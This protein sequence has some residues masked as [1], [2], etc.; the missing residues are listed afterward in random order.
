MAILPFP[1]RRL[2]G[3]G[4]PGFRRLDSHR[5]VGPP[6]GRPRRWLGAWLLVVAVSASGLPPV[7]GQPPG[8]VF[9]VEVGEAG[10]SD[11]EPA[12][13]SVTLV[14]DR[15]R[16]RQLDRCRRLVADGRWSDAAAACDELLADDRDAFIDR[17]D[18]GTTVRSIRGE[19][20][21][22]IAALPRP[23]RD[24]YLRLFR[25]RAERQLAE[26]VATGDEAGIAAVAR[27]WFHTP[28]GR[29]A[30]VI[31][32]V[33]AME[34]G[35]PLTAID[36]LDRIAAAEEGAE[37]EPTLT[38]MRALAR[39]QAGV[40]GALEM[41]SESPVGGRSLRLAG[42]DVELSAD[43]LADLL[44]G[45]I[46]GQGPTVSGRLGDWRQIRGGAAR[47]TV[48]EASRPLLVPRYRVPLTPHPAE[49][50]KLEQ[51][52]RTAADA[53]TPLLPAGNP[54]A[55]G[56][57]LVVRTSLGILAVDFETGKRRWLES[58]VPVEEPTEEGEAGSGDR[59]SGVFDDA[60]SGNLSSDG[61]LVFAVE[62]RP[63][64]MA[65]VEPLIRVFG[66][67]LVRHPAA[68]DG[69]NTLTAYDLEAG[70]GIR[71]QLPAKANDIEAGI[72][73]DE[74]AWFLGAP[75]VSGGE[76]LLLVERGG[77]A[78]LE[79]R[80]AEDGQ[81]L[82]RQPLAAYDDNE[83]I[84]SPEAHARRLAGLTPA[85]S[86]GVLVCPLGGG[87][88]V[89]FD[90]V[91]RTLLWSH[92]YQ[93]RGTDERTPRPL[94]EPCPVIVGD[95][96]LFNPFDGDGFMCLGLRD[97]RPAWPEPP[98]GRGRVAGVVD[99]RVI[100]VGDAAVEA[101]DI[102][103]GRRL[104]RLPL[105]DFGRPSGR[106]VTTPTSLLLPLDTPEVVEIGL[107]VGK[108][109]SRSP[110]RGGLIPGN[111]VAHRGEIVSQGVDSLD[112]FH[113]EAALDSRIE[114]AR[115]DAPTAPWAAYWRGQTAVE[116]GDVGTGLELV[117]SALKQG[118]FRIPPGGM[119]E[120]LLR[121]LARDFSTAARWAP[122]AEFIA[123]VP[124]VA[125]SYVDGC[126]AAGETAAAWDAFQG[127][128]A[129][130]VD[131]P[132]EAV[133]R[134]PA[135]PFLVLAADRWVRG[136]LARI[137]DAADPPLRERIDAA[138]RAAAAAAAADPDSAVRQRRME[139]VAERLGRHPAADGLIAR[140]AADVPAR[141]GRQAEV[142]A[143]LLALQTGSPPAESHAG[144]TDPDLA[145]P[146]GQVRRGRASAAGQQRL[147]GGY[148]SPLAPVPVT[149][150]AAGPRPIQARLDV[151][152]RRLFLTDGFGR[153]VTEPLPLEGA[154]R[155]LATPWGVDALEVA[156]AG[157]V[158]VVR[159][160]SE[161]VAYDIGAAVGRG[162]GL[163]R[164]PEYA[165]GGEFAGRSVAGNGRV[166]R[167]GSVSLGMRI[168]EPDE[169]PR[170][171]GRGLLVGARG[172]VV[173]GRQS[174]TCLDPASGRLAWERTRL[175]AGLEWC[176]DGDFVCGLTVSGHRSLV[177][178]ADDGR[179]LH[180]FD[181]PQRRQR[182]ATHGR[183]V[184]T[185][186]SSDELPGRFTARRVRLDLIDPATRQIR[187]LGDFPGDARATEAGPG[188]LAVMG[189]AGD[190]TI[191]D[192]D[193]AD[194]AVR[195]RLPD[196]PRRFSRLIVHPWEDRYLVFAG[197]PPDDGG[198]A[199]ADITPL[200]HLIRS[201]P[202]AAVMS[203]RLWAV[204]KTDGRQLWPVPV[205]IERQCFHTAQPPDLPV[206]VFCRQ[207]R[208]RGPR[209]NA[210]LSMLVLDK[211]TGHAV[212]EDDRIPIQPHGSPACDVSGDPERHAITIGESG[213]G[214]APT[215]LTFIGG[216]I[217]PQPPYR[218]RG[219]GAGLRIGAGGGLEALGRAARQLLDE[220][221]D[222]PAEP[223]LDRAEP[224][225]PDLPDLRFFDPEDFE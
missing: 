202:A 66:P 116:T 42:R 17:Q 61:R 137:R 62:S 126:L 185:V 32:A 159:T 132:P 4:V 119:N 150:A 121:A 133:V 45:Q 57:C 209:E 218:G 130:T 175:P 160:R 22:L 147:R 21:A 7:G 54:L 73:A 58:A 5:L 173:P 128:L 176:A 223:P 23:G 90:L 68:W 204:A 101:L 189:P 142:R 127:L 29:Q 143:A 65:P 44:P 170:G 87:C 102:E 161:L 168:G 153:P 64:A 172:V 85:L 216:P 123:G 219:R 86:D 144:G 56:D 210:A 192:L 19:A 183:S 69:G 103:T 35:H 51:Q 182:L 50:R 99:G 91:S 25:G 41:L 78:Q 217:P 187:P 40:P 151:E 163:W 190:L 16:E 24:A 63:V 96:V 84:T 2:P 30:A 74:A 154:G 184:V 89:A 15:G 109:S 105:A 188:R 158:L 93:R 186:L 8:N 10:S 149:G 124:A 115:R 94:G 52:R 110:A 80:V 43:G 194:V 118:G 33:A 157:R 221:S 225:L 122:A 206:L 224:A 222:E 26:A 49:S 100:M 146:L 82:W 199:A 95:R 27:R 114:A 134:D 155:E 171:D 179:L 220:R 92:A 213:S 136:R 177:F 20:A 211:R 53:G 31:M 201:S 88:L 139:A 174:V 48:V 193:A 70:G 140:L 156:V 77:E 152:Q 107:A 215:T 46:R 212:L 167:D 129:A 55:V 72:E 200:E 79:A 178:S 145:W 131:P 164:R 98:R 83:W 108:V 34:A 112:V 36:W 191:I 180:T 113:Q 75:L 38:V 125:R 207:L 11:R 198:D 3:P 117:H 18:A 165:G 196:P 111:L 104:W 59:P 169:I 97:G 162:R 120:I 12:E 28:A 39:R 208:S 6:A 1:F 47:N 181:V 67:G 14:N 197:G 81:L 203:G 13:P 135:D 106:G 76:L 214:A 205:V 71:W 138:C 195:V 60:T 9:G 37:F 148:A 141:G 166:A